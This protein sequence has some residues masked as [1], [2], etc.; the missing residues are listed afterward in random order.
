[1]LTAKEHKNNAYK[2]YKEWIMFGLSYGD[3]PDAVREKRIDV[4]HSNIGLLNNSTSIFHNDK[5]LIAETEGVI[6]AINELCPEVVYYSGKAKFNNSI[7]NYEFKEIYHFKLLKP[8]S[9]SYD[10]QIIKEL[11]AETDHKINGENKG[12]FAV[13]I[14]SKFIYLSI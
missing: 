13:D 8:G 12:R 6:Q 3:L 9:E 2:V 5:L 7:V 14:D 1:M 10:Y 4:V 11:Y